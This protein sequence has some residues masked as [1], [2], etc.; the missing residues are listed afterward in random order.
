MLVFFFVLTGVRI[1]L[2]QMSSYAAQ[3]LSLSIHQLKSGTSLS[4]GN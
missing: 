3:I 1:K 2:Y 4:V